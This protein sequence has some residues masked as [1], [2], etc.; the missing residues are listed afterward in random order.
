MRDSITYYISSGRKN[1]QYTLWEKRNSPKETNRYH[2]NTEHYICNLGINKNK[3]L[4]KAREILESTKKHYANYPNS[5]VEIIDDL[6]AGFG[7][8]NYGEGPVDSW[9][10]HNL[11]EVE[12]NGWFPFGKHLNIKFEDSPDSYVLWWAEKDLKDNK[13]KAIDA[14]VNACKK[15]ANNKKL[16]EKRDAELAERKRL[17]ALEPQSEYI[18]NVADRQKFEITIDF[19]K[20]YDSYY[21]TSWIV[22]GKTS[23]GNIVVYFGTAELG[24]VGDTVEFSAKI[25]KHDEYQDDKQTIVNRPT[26]IEVTNDGEE[27]LNT[28][29]RQ[30]LLNGV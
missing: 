29:E 16:F 7:L 14:I 21:G 15:I 18:G 28:K 5:N 10:A 22:K 13:K 25:K 8:N 3:A 23:D 11:H 2:R 1:A 4:K 27:T 17:K 12:T 26:K 30:A 19:L 9:D 20:S 24:N 6:N